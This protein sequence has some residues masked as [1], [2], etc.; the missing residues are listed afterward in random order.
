[1]RKEINHIT[2]KWSNDNGNP[3][4]KH[5]L[6]LVSISFDMDENSTLFSTLW[7][8]SHGCNFNVWSRWVVNWKSDRPDWLSLIM[9]RLWTTQWNRTLEYSTGCHASATDALLQMTHAHA[10]SK[11]LQHLLSQCLWALNRQT[12][13]GSP[14]FN[15]LFRVFL[16]II[17]LPTPYSASQ[18]I[19]VHLLKS[20]PRYDLVTVSVKL[21][22]RETVSWLLLKHSSPQQLVINMLIECILI[23][24]RL[25]FVLHDQGVTEI[26]IKWHVQVLQCFL[27]HWAGLAAR[28]ENVGRKGLSFWKY[29]GPGAW[30]PH[31]CS[32]IYTVPGHSLSRTSTGTVILCSIPYQ[33][34]CLSPSCVFNWP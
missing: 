11:A 27:F 3:K 17:Y 21:E 9:R 2:R 29:K 19:Q 4:S 13:R 14:W 5:F 30:M 7:S 15:L 26:S 32:G 12:F 28:P 18:H 10:L 31:E 16:S 8:H 6:F 20:D 24:Q 22:T 25:M 33:G 34:L 23:R 1:M